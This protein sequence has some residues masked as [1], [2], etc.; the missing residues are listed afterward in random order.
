MTNETP[1]REESS[2]E[3]KSPKAELSFLFPSLLRQA[4]FTIN[5]EPQSMA[6]R[7]LPIPNRITCRPL[8]QPTSLFRKVLR[9]WDRSQAIWDKPRKIS[10]EPAPLLAFCFL[11]GSD[12]FLWLP[13]SA[14]T[15]LYGLTLVTRVDVPSIAFKQPIPAFTLSAP[16]R[17]SWETNAPPPF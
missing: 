6:I 8:D 16:P 7:D 2:L 11:P 15:V 13:H 1:K 10:K 5:S 12:L 4:S 9:K 3:N 17:L 14:E